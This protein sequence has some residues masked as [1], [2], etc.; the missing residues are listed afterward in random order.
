MRVPIA[1]A[2]VCLLLAAFAAPA[3]FA[4]SPGTMG[5][6]NASCEDPGMIEPHGFTTDG[7]DNASSHYANLGVVPS[8]AN[9]HAVSQY[10]VACLE[11]TS[12]HSG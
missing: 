10:D 7:F 8:T 4:I 12:S 6:P 1:V 11:F 9:S 3:A 2:I 5:Q